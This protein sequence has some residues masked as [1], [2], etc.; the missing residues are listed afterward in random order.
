MIAQVNKAEMYARVSRTLTN[1]A[2]FDAILKQN[3]SPAQLAR[4]W[5]NLMNLAERGRP[6]A[7]KI[8]L[9]RLLGKAPMPVEMAGQLTVTTED[10]KH[11]TL[12]ELLAP[13]LGVR[14]LAMPSG[15]PQPALRRLPEPSN[16]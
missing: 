15:L 3:T 8:V 5:R 11:K 13:I 2:Q 1:R 9:D 14:P 6:W 7:I 16:E 10:R 12:A 4:I